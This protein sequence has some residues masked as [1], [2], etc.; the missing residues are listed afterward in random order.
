MKRGHS[1]K[2]SKKK[3]VDNFSSDDHGLD[4]NNLFFFSDIAYKLF[5]GHYSNKK[6]LEDDLS[7]I[8]QYDKE[9]NIYHYKTIQKGI[10]VIV[11]KTEE[12][13]RSIMETFHVDFDNK[14]FPLADLIKHRKVINSTQSTTVST[15]VKKGSHEKMDVLLQFI[16]E[17]K[18]EYNDYNGIEKD[19]IPTNLKEEEEY[20]KHWYG[21]LL[22]EIHNNYSKYCKRIGTKRMNQKDMKQYLVSNGLIKKQK[23]N[24]FSKQVFVSKPNRSLS[25]YLPFEIIR[26]RENEDILDNLD[27]NCCE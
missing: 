9:K 10:P 3:V 27:L 11:D 26:Q 18:Q 24:I 4:I 23:F 16:E 1:K 2:S 22:G 12:D 13:L 7:L 8:I 5:F 25:F 14:V 19:K 20:I 15:S 6:S 17:W 21:L